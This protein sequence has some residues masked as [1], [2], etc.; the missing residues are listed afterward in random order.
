MQDKTPVTL[1]EGS[2]SALSGMRPD[3]SGSGP[4]VSGMMPDCEVRTTSGVTE[5]AS[6]PCDDHWG[7]LGVTP[8]R[9]HLLRALPVLA[10][11]SPAAAAV[12][13]GRAAALAAA[14]AAGGAGHP[15]PLHHHHLPLG[16]AAAALGLRPL[17]LLRCRLSAWN[18]D[19]IEM[20]DMFD[21][22]L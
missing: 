4:G 9:P 18:F 7:Q 6:P 16:G 15:L 13:A 8:L 20:S 2:M 3:I 19:M 22:N 21:T 5:A 12:S 14:V 1:N 17:I 10:P 11:V